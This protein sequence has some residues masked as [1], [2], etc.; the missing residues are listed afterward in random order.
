MDTMTVSLTDIA[1][2]IFN[3]NKLKEIGT[4]ERR[5]Y[6]AVLKK[7]KSGIDPNDLHAN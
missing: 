1:R 7:V 5:I 3:K 6:D 2:S 4:V